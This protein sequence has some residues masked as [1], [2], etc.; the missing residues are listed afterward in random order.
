MQHRADQLFAYPESNRNCTMKS[1]FAVVSTLLLVSTV[2]I[3][4]GFVDDNSA[5]AH[6]EGQTIDVPYDGIYVSKV[7]TMGNEG[8]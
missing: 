1:I 7:D 2:V 3:G 8:P 4:C 6:F 5:P